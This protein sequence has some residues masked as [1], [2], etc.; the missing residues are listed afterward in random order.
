MKKVRESQENGRRSIKSLLISSAHSILI[1]TIL[2][3]AVSWAWFTETINTPGIKVQT[4]E[5]GITA[6]VSC[7]GAVVTEGDCSGVTNESGL[8]I[9]MESGKVHDVTLEAYGTAGKYGGYC[10][11]SAGDDLHYTV[12]IGGEN[13][14]EKIT[15]QVMFRGSGT[16]RMEFLP[17]W[18]TYPNTIPENMRI[19]VQGDILIH[20]GKYVVSD[21]DMEVSKGDMGVSSKGMESGR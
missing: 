4:A 17:Y 14:Q 1:C 15:F 18:G 12:P 3:G 21:E 20:E 2:L 10:V 16:G 5:Y 9:N 7:N 6:S 11:V 8:I 13:N 19:P